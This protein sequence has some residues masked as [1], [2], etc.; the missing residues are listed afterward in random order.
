MTPSGELEPKVQYMDL[1]FI[2]VNVPFFKQKKKFLSIPVQGL[3]WMALFCCS[4]PLTIVHHEDGRKTGCRRNPW[5]GVSWG[6]HGSYIHHYGR[7]DI[8]IPWKI[9][10]VATSV[11]VYSTFQTVEMT[12]SSL[13]RQII[14]NWGMYIAVSNTKIYMQY[15]K[16]VINMLN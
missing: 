3:P 1:H 5:I 13:K 9:V 8:G 2:L 4:V 12:C 15:S 7:D 11:I 14:T 6:I 16:H 10:L